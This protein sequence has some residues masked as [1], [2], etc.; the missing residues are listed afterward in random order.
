MDT[1]TAALV[2]LLQC[3]DGLV[4]IGQKPDS[5]IAREF[6]GT[7]HHPFALIQ[8]NPAALE[9]STRSTDEANGCGTRINLKGAIAHHRQIKPNEFQTLATNVRYRGEDRTPRLQCGIDAIDP[10]CV[11]TP[12]LNLRVENLP[13]FL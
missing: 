10:G 2:L 12:S 13:Q 11:K 8:V 7:A 3:D 9:H 4:L 5:H 1:Q 6:H